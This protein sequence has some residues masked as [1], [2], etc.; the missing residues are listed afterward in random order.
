MAQE[1]AVPQ[2]RISQIDVTHD[3][4][5]GRGGVFF[6]LRYVQN[7]R[8]YILLEKHLGFLKTSGK[9]L[10]LSQFAKQLLAYFID[11]SDMSMASFD[12]RKPDEGYAAVLENSPEDMASSHQ[13]KRFFRKFLLVPNWVHRQILLALFIWR[14]LKEQPKVIILFGDT[15]VLN[16]DDAEKREGVTPTYKK[17][18]GYQPLQ[19]SWGTYVV[20]A[21]FR[22]G[23]DHS[24]HGHD[25][26]KAIGRLVRA[27]R[28][29][30]GDVPII[31]DTDSGFMDDQN[32]RFFEERLGIG[33]ICGGK[34]YEELKT[35]AQACPAATFQT[36]AQDKQFWKYLEF[37]N[38]LKSWP[39]FRRCFFTT[40]ATE[41]N[42]Q[43]NLEFVQTDRFIYTNLGCDPKFTAQLTQAGASEYLQAATIIRLDHRRGQGELV[44]RALK[45][46][47]TKEQLPFERMG[48]NRAY[49][50][51][52][53]I[54]HFLYETYKRDIGNEI[55]PVACYPNTFR[56]RL[57]DFAVKIVTTGRKVIL[58]ATAGVF[59]QLHLTTLWELVHAPQPIWST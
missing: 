5:S 34:Q 32:F 35:Y 23:S 16:N 49:Y 51:F 27:I 44:H 19:I 8:F 25:F 21:L 29:F 17:K 2:N 7:T 26:M 18:K 28:R 13:M 57:I 15:M 40:L 39:K 6:F 24:N 1:N 11:G 48:M 56:R 33:Y 43:M 30:Y 3:T 55:V 41:V 50:Y 9:G 12:R 4:I 52:M 36:L 42:G 59:E 38:R 20:D 37:G 53:L 54:G 14:L 46:F 47:A 45:E 10:T 22:Q 31:V 58:K